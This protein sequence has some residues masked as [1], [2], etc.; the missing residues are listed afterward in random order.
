MTGSRGSVSLLDVLPPAS[1]H[2]CLLGEI[3][4]FIRA[5]V[6]RQLSL[7]NAVPWPT[8]SLAPSF[9]QVLQEQLAEAIQSPRAAP[10]APAPLSYAEV[11]A[12]PPQQTFSAPPYQPCPSRY[13]VESA[14]DVS[15]VPSP[16]LP[17]T[18]RS[19]AP[20]PT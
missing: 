3:K 19:A 9:R 12:Q 7:L 14:L 2:E 18:H 16:W 1:S 10:P 8:P 5:E 13:I 17:S 6:A 15:S 20:I 11:A 4:D